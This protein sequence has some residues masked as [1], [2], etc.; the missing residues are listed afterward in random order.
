MRVADIKNATCSTLEHLR[1]VII[2]CCCCHGVTSLTLS[3]H[4]SSLRHCHNSQ[5]IGCVRKETSHIER[6]D[7]GCSV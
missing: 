3:N 5:L 2:V 1:R 4:I 6:C 7:I